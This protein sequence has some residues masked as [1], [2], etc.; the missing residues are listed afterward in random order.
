MHAGSGMAMSHLHKIRLRRA[1]CHYPRYKRAV[2]HSRERPCSGK[3]KFKNFPP[4][5]NPFRQKPKKNENFNKNFDNKDF[6]NKD[7]KNKKT[8]NHFWP[9]VGLRCGWWP[10][11][12]AAVGAVG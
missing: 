5:V 8:K 11:V 9:E 12:E 6:K 1:F 2:G 10:V 7:F 3:A 4:V